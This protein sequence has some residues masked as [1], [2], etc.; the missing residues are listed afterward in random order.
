MRLATNSGQRAGSSGSVGR[1]RCRRERQ[2]A[3][4]RHRKA[5]RFVGRQREVGAALRGD[6]IEQL[7]HFR[8][9]LLRVRSDARSVVE[10]CRSGRHDLGNGDAME[11]RRQL[12][13]RQRRSEAARGQRVAFG[14]QRLPIAH[15]DRVRH[16]VD[17]VA[18]D[19]AEHR[20]HD[21]LAYFPGTEGDGLV[22]QRQAVAQRAV[23][24][25]REQR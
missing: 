19:S 1:G 5:R 21:A 11:Q 7:D 9:E 2:H 20:A 22:E 8:R 15:S 13:Q 3:Q 25:P 12:L 6:L 16:P 24:R 23:C 14:Q 17:V 10:T 18:L 4:Q